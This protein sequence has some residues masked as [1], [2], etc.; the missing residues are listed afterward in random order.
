MSANDGKSVNPRT[1]LAACAAALTLVI[2][3]SAVGEGSNRLTGDQIAAIPRVSEG[4]VRAMAG[5]SGGGQDVSALNLEESPFL[6]EP[7]FPRAQMRAADGA[8]ES[9]NRADFL[10]ERLLSDPGSVRA[11][12]ASLGLS[13]AELRK[14]VHCL[15]LNIY[16]EARNEPYEG[17]IAVAHVVLN[18]VS[19]PRFPETACKV[20]QQGGERIRHRCQFS[21]WCDGLSDRPKNN[22]KWANSRAFAETVYWGR[23]TDPT[24][25]ALW[26]HAD[27]VSPYWGQVFKRN[28]Q[29]GRH[30][31]YLDPDKPTQI[32]S[33]AV[34]QPNTP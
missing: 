2:Q 10:T 1:S 3:G 20:I 33:R 23:S 13:T 21:W 8:L 4:Q 17:Q 22:W 12:V 18:R 14:E 25:G 9:S 7:R 19:D 24:G 34:G 11:E 29:I 31:F 30:I 16:F 5:Q 6:I 32:A 26:Y 15:A 27:Y 28:R